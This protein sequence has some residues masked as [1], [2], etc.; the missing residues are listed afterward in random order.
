[1]D[2]NN[3]QQ[4][5][6]EQKDSITIEKNSRGFN[7]KFKIVAKEGVDIFKQIDHIKSEL[8]KRLLQWEKKK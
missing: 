1:M 7:Y 3:E 8:D 6:I 2:N 4:V 5:I